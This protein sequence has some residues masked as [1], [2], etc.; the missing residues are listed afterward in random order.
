MPIWRLYYSDIVASNALMKKFIWLLT[1]KNVK[2]KKLENDINKNTNLSLENG[3][4]DSILKIYYIKEDKI[5]KTIKFDH[6]IYVS[7][8]LIHHNSLLGVVIIMS[9]I[10]L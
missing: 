2:Q 7:S 1:Y 6:Y 5:I 3:R 9:K 8:H 10:L 4:F